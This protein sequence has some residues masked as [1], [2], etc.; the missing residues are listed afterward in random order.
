MKSIGRTALIAVL[1]ALLGVFIYWQMGGFTRKIAPGGAAAAPTGPAP[2][3]PIVK[4][5]AS[6]L[7]IIEEAVGTIQSRHR[8]DVSPQIQATILEVKVNSGDRVQAGDLLALLDP[9][10]LDARLG[11]ADQAVKAAAATHNQ[12]IADLERSRK[13]R[14]SNVISSQESERAFMLA[15]VT[16]A[17]LGEAYR[18]LEQ[19]KV[20]RSYA[21]IR[22]PVAGVI[23]EKQQ[24]AGDTAMPGKPIVSLYDPNLVRLEAPVRETAARDLRV[25]DVIAVRMGTED[26][27]TTGVIDEIV[28]QADVPSRSI[29]MRVLVSGGTN[30]YSGMY[31]RLLI[32]TGEE[33]VTLVPREAVMRVGQLEFALNPD[34]SKRFIQTGRTVADS[35]EVLAGLKPG[36]EVL[37]SAL[38]EGRQ[39]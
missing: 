25:G 3:G 21:E 26:R 12:A 30:L 19:A 11:Q 7:P 15:E 17:S 36:D 29:L 33:K 10:D 35:L 23:V 16:S 8:V 18:A 37:A 1:V 31:G 32:R 28:P 38:A 34:G 13:L 24:Q 22:S 14:D 39:P 27:A 5:H 20:A 9:R 6:V 4:A 2:V